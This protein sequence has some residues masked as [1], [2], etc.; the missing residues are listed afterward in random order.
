LTTARQQGHQL[1]VRFFPPWFQRQQAAG[2]G[3]G[4]GQVALLVRV[5]G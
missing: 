4:Y 1:A 2:M 5:I 3:D